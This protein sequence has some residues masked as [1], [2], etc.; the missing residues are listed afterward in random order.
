V[1]QHFS[2]GGAAPYDV[3]L[4]RGPSVGPGPWNMTAPDGVIDLQND[5]LG[6]L[7]QFGHDCR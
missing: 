1:I 4:D 6:V 5:L 2:P 7:L 3:A